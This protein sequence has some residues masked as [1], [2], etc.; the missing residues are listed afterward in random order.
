MTEHLTAGPKQHCSH[1][2]RQSR[3]NSRD[4]LCSYCE[5]Y[6]HCRQQKQ[7]GLALWCCLTASAQTGQLQQKACT[8]S[9][10]SNS[11]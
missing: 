8:A 10:N 7:Q 4:M 2:A 1:P 3:A 9:S 5:L 11:W 6:S